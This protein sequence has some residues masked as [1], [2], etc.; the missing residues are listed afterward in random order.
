[1][2]GEQLGATEI[3]V[4]RWIRYF[5]VADVISMPIFFEIICRHAPCSIGA[6]FKQL[7]LAS[8]I[9]QFTIAH[10]ESLSLPDDSSELV[11]GVVRAS[12]QAAISTKLAER[13]SSVN[14]GEGERFQKDM[15]LISFDCQLYEGK[16]AVAK[17]LEQEMTVSLKS[18]EFLASRGSG[19]LNN[20]K[21]AKARYD[22]AS[23]ETRII[24]TQLEQCTIKA[25]FDGSV[26]QVSIHEHEITVPGEPLMSIVALQ[27]PRIEMIV[28]SSW[29]T[30]ISSDL[31]FQFRIDET[32]NTYIGMIDRMSASVDAVSQT[33]KVFGEF[34]SA[35]SDVIPGMSG[36]VEF[37]PEAH[38][39]TLRI[40]P[41]IQMLNAP[42]Q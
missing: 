6:L 42:R 25:P 39:Q 7:A 23:S 8:A 3:P 2:S 14:F 5:V 16:L 37:L 27:D 9:A 26:A 19:N 34:E 10:A 15:T 11:R 22:R 32:G 33:I 38:L 12:A 20:F 17:A 36:T 28:P 24:E 21:I 31:R 41:D 13:V 1:M 4:G 29:L 30:W 40:L 18:A 35:T